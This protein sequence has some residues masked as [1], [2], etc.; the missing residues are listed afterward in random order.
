[1]DCWNWKGYENVPLRVSTYSSCE[2]V[3]LFLN[4]KS[5][6]SKSTDRSTRFMATWDVPYR[7]GI[8]KVA[9]YHGKKKVAESVL[10]TAGKPDRIR[11]SADR[12]L[13]SADNQDLCYIT[14]EI[15]DSLGIR[16][17]LAENLVRFEL[18]GPGTIVGV[19]NGNPVSLES[20]LLPQRKAWQ[21]RC[22]VIVRA[23]KEAGTIRVK[24]ISDGLQD[25]T[26]EITTK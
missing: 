6:G 26:V 4:G 16:N 2:R 18:T 11:I 17:P 21:G 15:T 5:M 8:L 3:E 10:Q 1:V 7:A 13:I 22:L 14:V 12:H 9:G 20:C 23:G 24:A 25:A 19:G